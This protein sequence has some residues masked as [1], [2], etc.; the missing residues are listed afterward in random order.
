MMKDQKDALEL[1][2][3][4]IKDSFSLQVNKLF[5]AKKTAK[6]KMMKETL[7]LLYK[8][9]KLNIKSIKFK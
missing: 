7:L 4:V 2:V 9:D 3:I 1:A 5:R 8:N 6:L